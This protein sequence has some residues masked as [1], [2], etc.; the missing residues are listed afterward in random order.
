MDTP[1]RV[2]AVNCLTPLDEL[3]DAP[4]MVD[5]RSQMAACETWAAGHG[6]TVTEQ[7]V[8][9]A[10]QKRHVEQWE[11]PFD[12]AVAPSRPV[13]E[14]AVAD[15]DAFEKTLAD[16]GIRL[17]YADLPEPDYTRDMLAR[18]HRRHSLP[19]AGYDGS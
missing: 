5:T 11:K 2:L 3:H 19:T 10:L 8:T 7:W 1:L 16:A 14:R 18:I 4:F 17:E 15:V 6:G 12:V 9:S 13:L